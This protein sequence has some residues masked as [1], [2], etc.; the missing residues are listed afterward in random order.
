MS[1]K[2]QLVENLSQRQVVED[3]LSRVRPEPEISAARVT[4]LQQRIKQQLIEKNAV[5]IAR[6]YTDPLNQAL[7]EE[8]GS[9]WW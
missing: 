4:E 7:A 2:L 5:L 6:Y 8:T 9:V 1:A 3:Y